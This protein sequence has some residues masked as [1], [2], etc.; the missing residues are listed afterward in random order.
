[1]PSTFT[2]LE[3]GKSALMAARRAMEVTGHNVAN[4]ATPGYSRQE[5]VL[6]PLIQR[7]PLSSGVSGVGVKVADVTRIRDRFI[8]AV[9]RNEM[10]KKESFAVQKEVLDHLQV[11]FAEP[12]DSSLRQAIDDFWAAWH[13]LSSNP[14][15]EAARSQVMERGRTLTDLFR[16]LGSQLDSLTADIDANIQATVNKINLTSEKIAVLNVE[17]SRALARKEP[18]ADLMDRRDLLLDELASLSGATVTHLDEGSS[19]R[20]LLGGLPI[21]DHQKV[22]KIEIGPSAEIR[23]SLG[24]GQYAVV[25]AVG[26]RLGG[27]KT[28][29]NDIVGE[30][31]QELE[32]M[33]FKLVTGVNGIHDDG[34]SPSG[35]SGPFFEGVAGDYLGTVRVVQAIQEDPNAICASKTD[36]L[37]GQIA[38]DIA[39]YLDGTSDPSGT[40]FSDLWMGIVGRLGAVGQKV[41]GGFDTQELLVKE[42]QNR[43]DSVSGVS[44]DEEVANLIREQHAFNA[45]SRVISIADE[46]LD[47]II[48]RMGMA[49]R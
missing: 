26:G 13:D 46:M 20:V 21:V 22:Y 44:I 3:I 47:T 38:R 16:H 7:I 27:L 39:N 15:S 24:N 29:R 18:V 33:L 28:A 45:A 2:A 42:L 10:G 48:N 11:V 30:F 31:K 34:I 25:D 41:E 4:A 49:G 14:L 32:S 43:R 12:S 17:I 8:D 9:L 6:E 35:T 23:V 1:M 19:V 36:P 40:S 5:V 37:D